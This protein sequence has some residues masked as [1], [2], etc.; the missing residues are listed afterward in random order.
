MILR[1][2]PCSCRYQFLHVT[3]LTH[4]HYYLHLTHLPQYVL[5][6]RYLQVQHCLHINLHCKLLSSLPPSLSSKLALV[7]VFNASFIFLIFTTVFIFLIYHHCPN[8]LHL[9]DC[10]YIH[11]H[12]PH[13]HH[14][15][16]T[17]A[18][19]SPLDSNIIFLLHLI[20]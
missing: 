12:Y 4:H 6:S 13:Q 19:S 7:I 9:Q 11:F 16:S 2:S 14:L 17:S 15:L 3:E 20:S 10:P 8:F 5:L 18:L 1:V